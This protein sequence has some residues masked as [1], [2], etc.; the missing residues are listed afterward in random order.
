MTASGEHLTMHMTGGAVQV[1]S[2][3]RGVRE[4][5]PEE[6]R[7]EF[8]ADIENAPADQL[9]FTLLRWAMNIPTEHDE[10]EEDLAGRVRSGDTTGITFAEDLGDDAYRGI[11]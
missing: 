7:A 5:L 8:T 6:L 1:P 2:T 4:S 9:R 3:I 11:E 10:T